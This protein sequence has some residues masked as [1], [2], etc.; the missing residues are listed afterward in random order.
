MRRRLRLLAA[1]SLALCWYLSLR[2]RRRAA[3]VPLSPVTARGY[4]GPDFPER[5]DL[6]TGEVPAGEMDDMAH[7]GRPD[8]DPDRVHPA[9]RDFY[10][11]TS[12]YRMTATVTWHRGFRLGAAL[13]A[14][15]TSAVEQLNLPGPREDS[16][17]PL[18]SRFATVREGIDPRDGVR[19]WVR[20]NPETGEAVFVALYGSHDDGGVDRIGD[21]DGDA[22]ERHAIDAE[23]GGPAGS[24]SEE[25]YVND[26]GRY[27]NVA[28]PIPWGNVSTALHIVHAGGDPDATGVDLTTRTGERSGLYLVTP[29]GDVALPVEQ[30]FAVR[31]ATGHHPDADAAIT[32]T[33]TMWL[34]GVP[35]LTIEYDAVRGDPG[36]A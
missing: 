1:A 29:L 11:A 26:A 35:F 18:E 12:A 13:A 36:S 30:R 7:Y 24:R 17:V 34:C 33:Q 31:P 3:D 21:G 10:E 5:T 15:A 9:V 6:T 28:V 8:F 25:R 16:T 14:R 27:V 19:A 2:A 23:A 22:G 32:A 20:T 4:V